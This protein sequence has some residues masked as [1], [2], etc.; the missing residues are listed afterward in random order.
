MLGKEK[1]ASWK[2]TQDKK[3]M[4]GT[5]EFIVSEVDMFSPFLPVPGTPWNMVKP[6]HNVPS[7]L[8]CQEVDVQELIPGKVQL[9]YFF[10][11]DRDLGESF[12]DIS[13]SWGTQ[14]VEQTKGYKWKNSG[15]LIEQEIP[16]LESIVSVKVDKKTPAPARNL[17]EQSLNRVNDRKFLGF[18]REFLLF[19]G[20]EDASSYNLD[21]S[22]LSVRTSFSFTGKVDRSH[23]VSWRQP[24]P[25]RL[26]DGNV[27]YWQNENPAEPYFSND[28]TKIGT[29]VYVP[30]SAGLGA[31][32]IIQEVSN[33]LNYR[34][35]F[36][37][38]ATVLGI[39]TIA[40]DDI[41]GI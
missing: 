27:A 30:G 41:P 7:T 34:Y 3:G 38:F 2:L 24:I 12:V 1:P 39:P 33:P 5:I 29:M 10:S 6:L 8:V 18:P 17:L 37:D 26:S 31:F 11:T 25:R 16:T 4:T 40:G 13:Y 15:T 32:D 19:D 22:I 36:C 23:N 9:T 21:G 14:S 20:I 35:A 28:N